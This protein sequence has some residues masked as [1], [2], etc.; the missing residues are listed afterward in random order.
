[1]IGSGAAARTVF[2]ARD[3][4]GGRP[5]R[6]DRS[7]G[8]VLMPDIVRSVGSG[9]GERERSAPHRFLY[10]PLVLLLAL[11][12]A[13]SFAPAA[14]L[15]GV[16]HLAFYPRAVR[17]AAL[18]VMVLS[19]VPVVARSIHG[20]A[21]WV[22]GLPA[23]RGRLRWA[24]VAAV[25]IISLLV[26][27]RFQSATLLLGDGR[28][29]ART[30][31]AAHEKEL[32]DGT[33]LYGRKAIQETNAPGAMLLYYG[34]AKAT[35]GILSGTEAGRI[36]A[37]NCALGC[38]FIFVLL[39]AVSGAIITPVLR[40]WMAVLVLT[41]GAMTLFFGYVETYTPLLLLAFLYVMCAFMCMRRGKAVWMAM[42]VL[43]LAAAAFTHI[44]GVLLAPSFVL[45]FVWFVPGRRRPSVLKPASVVIG[46]VVIAVAVLAWAFTRYGEH[47]LTLRGSADT[48]GM[49]SWT[50]LLDVLNELLLLFPLFPL[51]G[52]MGA[53][54][55][56]RD[57]G[58]HRGS[59]D[60]KQQQTAED[61]GRKIIHAREPLD[62]SVEWCFAVLLLVPAIIFLLVFEP[63][64]GMAR[65]WDLFSVTLAGLVP[66]SL[67]IVERAIRGGR[68]A[69]SIRG[70]TVPAAVMGIVLAAAWIGINADAARSTRRFER[71]LEYDRT[72][73]AYAY[74]ILAEHY[75]GERDLGN[76][77]EALEKVVA[78]SRNPRQLVLLGEY[79]EEDGRV[80]DAV[81]ILRSVLERDP[82]HEMARHNLVVY[83]NRAR[84][85]DELFDIAREGVMHHPDKAIFRA[86]RGVQAPPAAAAGARTGGEHARRA[87]SG[88]EILEMPAGRYLIAALSAAWILKSL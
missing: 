22:L 37:I 12:A 58:A 70:V 49:V 73:L 35:R 21:L 46:N 23:L 69:S 77:I 36:R 56:Y 39:L 25:S 64:I 42:T 50:H 52:L 48:Y 85:Y 75:H 82:D 81:R 62:R 20:A 29:I 13:A 2:D 30:L 17:L 41:S 27:V 43:C 61:A 44:Q 47:F 19:F 8:V 9:E 83:L 65:D 63:E 11:V 72:N 32:E 33:P 88:R 3:E 68:A 76:A 57:R 66:I 51:I 34:A 6:E 79:Y 5:C 86:A 45:L 59:G 1:M 15:W 24:A 10:V 38:I 28:L 87:Q 60:A 55:L 78:V 16:N 14:R 40:L 71:I 26:F 74:E 53:A 67:L 7:A 54:A 18:G 31:E 80:D 4:A 84:R